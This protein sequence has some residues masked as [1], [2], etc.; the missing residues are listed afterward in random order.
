ME[1]VRWKNQNKKIMIE[2]R[3]RIYIKGLII[4]DIQSHIQEIY[5][6][7]IPTK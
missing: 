6:T 3:Y 5:R 7:A 1:I 4:R 2:N